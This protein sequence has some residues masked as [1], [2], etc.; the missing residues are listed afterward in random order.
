MKKLIIR[1]N[2]GNEYHINEH[3]NIDKRDN[4]SN[5]EMMERIRKNISDDVK[6]ISISSSFKDITFISRSSILKL[7]K[8]HLV[9]KY[10]SS[11]DLV[12]G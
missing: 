6:V 1:M 7:N 9:V 10:I 2:N 3:E 5:T 12:E 4:L 8:I 11:I